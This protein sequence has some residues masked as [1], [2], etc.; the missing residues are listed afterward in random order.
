MKKNHYELLGVS[1]MASPEEIK[2]SYRKLALQYHP[3]TNANKKDAS[4]MFKLISEA[5]KV[6]MDPESRFNYDAS[7][8]TT[9]PP[10]PRPHTASSKTSGTQKRRVPQPNTSA[11]A[12]RNLVY[13][14]NVSIDDLFRNTKKT[15]SYMRTHHGARQS[16]T[17]VVDVPA[18]VPNGQKLRLRGAGESSSAK[19]A[20]GDLIVHIHYAEHPWFQ[21]DDHDLVLTVPISPLQ[22]LLKDIIT[23]PTP[24]GKRDIAIPLE[25]EFGKLVVQVTGLGLPVKGSAKQFGDLYVKMKVQSPPPL[26]DSA[27][28]EVRK[29]AKILP[30]SREELNFEEYLKNYEKKS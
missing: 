16:S 20:P 28:T 11:S 21:A 19:Q 5:Y 3:D 26:S 13:H 1:T 7:L 25:D 30:K 15:I 10:A 4:E 8:K 22:W 18:G 6:L 23:I 29:L 9:P 14:L 24:H 27:R 2:K 12:G 17:V